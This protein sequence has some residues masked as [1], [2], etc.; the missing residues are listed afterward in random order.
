MRHRKPNPLVRE[1]VH[2]RHIGAVVVVTIVV[3][4]NRAQNGNAHLE[5]RVVALGCDIAGVD[6]QVASLDGAQQLRSEVAMG[7][8]DDVDTPLH[9]RFNAFLSGTTRRRLTG[10]RSSTPFT[11]SWMAP[12]G[13]VSTSSTLARLT[14]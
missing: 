6:K 13:T 10:M 11:P 8:G 9:Y 12:E 5:L 4:Q 3:A 7:I 14:M 1:L 2:T